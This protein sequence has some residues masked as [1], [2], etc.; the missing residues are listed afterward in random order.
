VE[1][2]APTIDVSADGAGPVL[3]IGNTGDPATPYEGAEKM[4]DELG[5]GVG[6]H[7]T[8]D[9]EGHGTYGVNDCLTRVVDTYLLAGS[10][11]KNGTSCS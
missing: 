9:G 11:P 8:V 7:L 5:E 2:H 6:V 10:V 3:V 4:A 1:G